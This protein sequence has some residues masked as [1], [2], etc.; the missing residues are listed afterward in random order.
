M[1][2]GHFDY[3]QYHITDIADKVESLIQE[4]LSDFA[5]EKMR[6]FNVDTIEEFQKALRIFRQAAVYANRIDWLV[7][8]DDGEESFHKRLRE[9]LVKVNNNG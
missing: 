6:E 9:D 8:G 4:N 5:Y 7:S 1:S 3:K 2:G